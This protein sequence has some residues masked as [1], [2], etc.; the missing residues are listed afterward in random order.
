MGVLTKSGNLRPGEDKRQE[1]ENAREH[2]NAREHA[3]ACKN[4]LSRFRVFYDINLPL[5]TFGTKHSLR[6]VSA[7]ERLK[8][9]NTIGGRVWQSCLLISV[10]ES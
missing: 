6:E 7:Y 8:N 4:R 5:Y 9:T 1:H 2:T 3:S 10:L